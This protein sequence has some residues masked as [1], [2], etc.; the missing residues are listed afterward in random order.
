[1]TTQP[2]ALRLA[3]LMREKPDSDGHCRQA[4]AELRRLH[5]EVE[6]LRDS[7]EAK[8]DRIDRLGESVERLNARLREVD[9]RYMAL[10][11]AVA[12]GVAMQ[13]KTIVLQA[14]S[15]AIDAARS[16]HD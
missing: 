2:E 15:A 8:A 7:C 16:G 6:A 10:L 4:A 5:A 9:A 12:D 11:K 13:P 3:E 1:M 14:E